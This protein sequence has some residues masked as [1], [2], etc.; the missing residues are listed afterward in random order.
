VTDWVIEHTHVFSAAVS[1]EGSDILTDWGVKSGYNP[2][3][4]WATG[5]KDPLK[6]LDAFKKESVLFHAD[7]VTTPTMFINC[8]NGGNSPSLPW[9]SAALRRS[10]DGST[11]IWITTQ[12]RRRH[13]AKISY[14]I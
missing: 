8:E 10:S 11:A 3:I 14:W 4:E 13:R 9:L 2:G 1:F 5:K 6:H 12:T 7:G